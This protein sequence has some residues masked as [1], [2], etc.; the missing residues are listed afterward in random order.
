MLPANLA[1][2]SAGHMSVVVRHT[3]AGSFGLVIASADCACG[4]R[5]VV[6]R[7]ANR[8]ALAPN[9][10]TRTIGRCTL[11]NIWTVTLVNGTHVVLGDVRAI[12]LGSNAVIPRGPVSLCALKVPGPRLSRR[13]DSPGRFI[14]GSR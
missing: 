12:A 8:D 5:A 1:T 4:N 6:A 7:P 10:R 9:S 13:P 3:S 11:S 2:A 14:T